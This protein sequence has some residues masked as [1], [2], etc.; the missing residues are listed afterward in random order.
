MKRKRDYRGLALALGVTLIVLLLRPRRLFVVNLTR[1]TPRGLYALSS[2]P[3]GVDDYI[4]IEASKLAFSN[5][6]RQDLL[7]VK[8]LAY[9]NREA[10]TVTGNALTVAGR[11]YAKYR[12]AGIALD[13]SLASGEGLLLGDHPRS[14]DSRYFGPV[15]LRDCTRAVPLFLIDRP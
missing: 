15:K 5:G 6:L 13:A 7:L 9:A 4:V 2:R 14:F 10:F 1:S 3:P 12:P 11:T 8:R